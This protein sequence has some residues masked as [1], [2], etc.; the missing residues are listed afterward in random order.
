MINVCQCLP[1]CMWYRGA[2]KFLAI[3]FRKLAKRLVCFSLIVKICKGKPTKRLPVMCPSSGM[4][5]SV[6]NLGGHS[7]KILERKKLYFVITTFSCT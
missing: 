3:K 6:S 7:L 4:Y 1:Y 2:D 5:I